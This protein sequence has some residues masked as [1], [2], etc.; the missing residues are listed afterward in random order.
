M[1]LEFAQTVREHK[2]TIYT[3]CYLFSND[4]EEVADLYQEIL[5][6]L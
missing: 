5:I 4:T 2:G 1:E 6:N 3:V